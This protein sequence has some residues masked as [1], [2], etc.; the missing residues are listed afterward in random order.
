MS[1]QSNPSISSVK[2]TPSY[3]GQSSDADSKKNSTPTSATPQGSAQSASAQQQSNAAQP[4]AKRRPSRAGTRSVS[5]LTAAQ[6]ERKRAND[7]EAQRAIR[8]R[9]K[10]HIE[11]LERRVAELTAREQAN[12][13][14]HEIMQ[15]ND[16]LE[17]ENAILRQ[18]LNHALA[19]L[20]QAGYAESNGLP[21]ESNILATSGAPSPSDRI[22][23]MNQPRPSSTPTARSVPS[24]T[25][26]SVPNVPSQ[27]DQWHHPHANPH[28]HTGY[29]QA[30]TTTGADSAPPVDVAAPPD[31]MRWS[32]H[33]QHVNAP[34]SVAES[35]M[36]PVDNSVPHSMGYGG[37]VLDPNGRPVQSQYEAQSQQM[38]Y[39]HIPVSNAPPPPPSYHDQRHLPV[40]MPNPPSSYSQYPQPQSYIPSSHHGDPMIQR[41]PMEGQHMMYS[42]PSNVKPE[43]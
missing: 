26:A 33:G 20:G 1:T 36:H 18:R 42:I 43:Q 12:G 21:S 7:R 29:N 14:V 27:A 9:T 23:I 30:P 3:E 4:G 40:Q 19:A 39:S 16:E 11:S 24:V 15:R 32:P 10:D 34:V 41:S 6:L 22:H 8:Q 35:S 25:G 31:A 2:T 37:Y 28:A 17:Q 5:T 13:R 38:G